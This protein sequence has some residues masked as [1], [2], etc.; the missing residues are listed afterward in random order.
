MMMDEAGNE[1]DNDHAREEENNPC[2]S[3]RAR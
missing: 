3:G 1:A 2:I